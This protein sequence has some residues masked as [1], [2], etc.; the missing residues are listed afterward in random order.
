MKQSLLLSGY[1]TWLPGKCTKKLSNSPIPSHSKGWLRGIF[2][3]SRRPPFRE[4]LNHHGQKTNVAPPKKMEVWVSINDDFQLDT[5]ASPTAGGAAACPGGKEQF[6]SNKSP[7][8]N[9]GGVVGMVVLTVP[10]L[11]E[12]QGTRAIRSITMLW[13][14]LCRPEGVPNL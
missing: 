12:N 8:K 6:L 5:L 3:D 14:F 4:S 13:W 7:L 10:T 11:S 1:Q 9:C 2:G